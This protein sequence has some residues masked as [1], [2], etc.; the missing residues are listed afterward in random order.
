M[1]EP[2]RPV[3]GDQILTITPNLHSFLKRLR[4]D[5]RANDYTATYWA[6]QVCIN[7]KD[8]PKR[9]SQVAMMASI[10]PSLRHQ[11]NT[12]TRFTRA[13]VIQEVALAADCTVRVSKDVFRW[14]SMDL[15]ILAFATITKK[16]EGILS[17]APVLKTTAAAAIRHIQYCRRTWTSKNAQVRRGDFLHLLGRLSAIMDCTDLRDRVYAYL[18]LQDQ[19]RALNAD[20]SLTVDEVFMKTSAE[21]AAASKGLDIFA[22]TR[23][24]PIGYGSKVLRV[25]SWAIEW[26]LPSTRSGLTR[27]AGSSFSASGGFDYNPMPLER[28]GLARALRFSKT[29]DPFTM[30]RYLEWP[31]IIEMTPNLWIVRPGRHSTT[32]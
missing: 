30:M 2:R 22:Y 1:V 21:L 6:V 8:V 29:G 20:Y 17:G 3:E 27:S 11:I 10:Y 9:N 18:S 7:Q 12:S 28:H 16:R 19:P 31:W 24:P 13:W 25:T 32:G 14:E 26:H 15:A 5:E 4:E 23:Y